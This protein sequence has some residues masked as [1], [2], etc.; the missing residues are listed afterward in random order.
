[1]TLMSLRSACYPVPI[2]RFAHLRV[3][4]MSELRHPANNGAAAIRRRRI[5][6]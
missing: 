5:H 3:S 2:G 1:M 6:P 4:L